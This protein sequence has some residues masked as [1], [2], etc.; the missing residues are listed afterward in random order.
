MVASGPAKQ[1]G[2]AQVFSGVAP[3]ESEEVGA[4]ETTL[5]PSISGKTLDVDGG[6]QSFLPQGS[7]EYPVP[8]A[9]E[10]ST[11]R[12]VAGSIPIASYVLCV[13]ELA[14]RASYFGASTVFSNFMEFPLPDK[15]TATGA[16]RKGDTEGHAGALNKGLQFATAFQLLFTFLAYVFPILGAWIAD[17][18]LGRFK[19]IMLGVILGGVAHVIMI[20]GA[21]PA[22]LRAGRGV[23]PFLVSLFLLAIGAGIFKPNV[24]PL[25]IDQY[26]HQHAYVKTL[27]SSPTGEKV[28]VD[29][30]RTIQRILLIFYAMINIGSFFAIATTYTEKYI[31]FW[32]S[33]LL[34]GIVYFLLPILLLIIYKRLVQRQPNE[35]SGSQLTNFLKI[36]WTAF[37]RNRGAVWRKDFWDAAK[38]ATLAER[39]V[40]VGWTDRAVVDVQRTFAAT[41]VFLYFPI[42]N[43]N[44]GG[45]GAVSSNQGA[46]MTNHG[47]PND[48]L[49]N[50]NPV[51]IIAFTP[52]LTYGLYPLLAH[53]NI[54][55]GP[56]RRMTFGFLLAAVSGIIGA[57]VQWRVYVTSPCGY[58]ASTCA[59]LVAADAVSVSPLSIWWQFPNIALGAISELFC[60]VTAY[61][62]AYVR[63]PPQLKSVVMAMF[64]FT[65]ALSNALGEILVPA[66]IDPHL[67]WVWAGPAIALFAQTAVFYFRH[68]KLDDEIYM[69][70]QNPTGAPLGAPHAAVNV[71]EAENEKTEAG[72]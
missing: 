35:E 70:E 4:V 29:P 33:F 52:I 72:P 14:E 45:I 28:I 13:A 60:N 51:V 57:I 11:L 22:V 9:E 65:N 48:L 12:R 64:L 56:I 3:I 69:L 27:P 66:I 44:D 68:R 5:A 47:T 40:Y 59:D 8:T 19:T 36:A 37:R 1:H 50:L 41:V 20:G 10:S 46:S 71:T 24:A 61:E 6:M 34:P 53:Y 49:N 62:M 25:L 7:A 38:P 32:V 2:V 58:N 31:G 42:Y 55:F 67:V 43:I 17:V 63:A 21:A 23:A 15:E 54:R 18:K 26:Q 39:G 30:E 16:V